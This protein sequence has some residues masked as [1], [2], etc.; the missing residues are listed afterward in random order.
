MA[1]FKPVRA[2]EKNINQIQI[3]DGQLI[4]TEEGNMYADFPNGERIKCSSQNNQIQSDWEQTDNTQKDYIKNKP[5]ILDKAEIIKIIEQNAII[6]ENG[7]TFIPA[8]SE[9]GI[10]SWTNDKD[11]N[12]PPPINIKGP[13]GEIGYYIKATV[14][15][16]AFSESQWTTYGTIGREESWGGTS[17]ADVRIGDLFIIV[18]TSTDAGQGHL[19]VYKYTGVK[20]GSTLSGTCIGHHVI[21]AK[22]ATGATGKSAYATAKEGGYTGTEEQFATKLATT[23]PKPSIT[24]YPKLSGEG[25]DTKRFQRALAENRVLYIPG[26]EYFLSDTLT[27]RENCELELAQ[28][29]VL[30]F[31]QTDKN[32]IVLLRLA[33]LKGNHATIF[34]SYDFGAN[35]LHSDTNEDEKYAPDGN[36]NA[37]AVPPFDKWDPQWKMSR[38]ITDINICKP[39]HRGFHYSYGAKEY[40]SYNMEKI[41]VNGKEKYKSTTVKEG[42][43]YYE[44]ACYGTAV[45]FECHRSAANV[46]SYMWGISATGIRISGAFETGIRVYNDKTVNAY[47]NDNSPWN[48]DARIEAVIDGCETGVLLHNTNI[49]HIAATIQPRLA[50]TV[51]TDSNGD[52]IQTKYAKWGIKLV[53]SK[54]IDLTQSY[55]W[56][57]QHSIRNGAASACEYQHIAMYG[58]CS[59]AH[60]S[61]FSLATSENFWQTIYY[62]N[63]AS[64]LT[65]TISGYKGKV[66]I[67]PKYAFYKNHRNGSYEFKKQNLSWRDPHNMLRYD[68]PVAVVNGNTV[69]NALYQVGHFTINGTCEN[70]ILDNKDPASTGNDYFDDKL[71][72]E[73]IT[74]EENDHY[75]LV[76]WSNLYCDGSNMFH[77]W[78]PVV[79]DPSNNVPT[80]YY[81]KNA[82]TVEYHKDDPDKGGKTSYTATTF[83]IY[84]LVPGWYDLQHP[85]NCRMSITNSRRFIFDF[86]CVGHFGT[87]TV[88]GYSALDQSKYTKI[89][90]VLPKVDDGVDEAAVNELIDKQLDLIV[91]DSNSE[92]VNGEPKFTTLIGNGLVAKKDIT[93]RDKSGEPPTELAVSGAVLV[94]SELSNPFY[95]TADTTI[96]GSKYAII[97][98]KGINFDINYNGIYGRVYSISRV[99]HSSGNYQAGDVAINGNMP[100]SFKN[101]GNEGYVA[102]HD[103]YLAYKWDK[104][105]LLLELHIRADMCANHAF[106]FTGA[107]PSGKIE[108]V[109]VTQNNEKIEWEQINIGEPRRLA[110]DIH[111]SSKNLYDLELPTDEHINA[112]IDAKLNSI[113][114]ASDEEEGF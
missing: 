30:N 101:S 95:F 22:G 6:G 45:N 57:W 66:P 67:D 40:S 68:V 107:L 47:G 26:G 80:Y 15:R 73:T 20:G 31:T 8:I 88:G 53:D 51:R 46:I 58:D 79:Y 39:D 19:L 11:L 41:I 86:K 44:K 49:L 14:D 87:G 114:L 32:C 108:D 10:I 24:D 105:N 103:P 78:K 13:Q 21:S 83:T 54:G 17:N 94:R 50:M 76:G 55:V 61:D 112:L 92:Y 3:Q 109:I 5:D 104:E 110:P 29:A 60:I 106:Y 97:R 98:V 93:I 34:V 27:I 59:G 12:N 43:P 48:H 102:G 90:T 63:P 42:S 74:I 62:D 23:Y 2:T 91:L 18:G 36:T 52:T 71:S 81:T 113:P 89:N 38:Y 84:K 70:I 77:Y 4:L 28:D 100:L 64:M 16:P 33:S 37:T 111:I 75:G 85:Y 1:Q 7:A 99:N 82:K 69:P 72:V 25:D 56:D 35:V 9:N 96:D 65:A